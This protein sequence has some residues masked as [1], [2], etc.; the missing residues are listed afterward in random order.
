MRFEYAAYDADLVVMVTTDAQDSEECGGAVAQAESFLFDPLTRRPIFAELTICE[1]MIAVFDFNNML[2]FVLQNVLKILVRTSPT[3]ACCF[4]PERHDCYL[5]YSAMLNA[6]V[7]LQVVH[8]RKSQSAP[9]S[10]VG[11][12]RLNSF[13]FAGCCSQWCQR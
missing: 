9:P 8:A 1:P 4:T 7:V 11:C 12:S 5:D 2:Q 13:R 3:H 6:I 10:D